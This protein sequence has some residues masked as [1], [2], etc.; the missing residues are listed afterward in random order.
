MQDLKL[1]RLSKRGCGCF[2]LFD[3][4]ITNDLS[5]S[6]QLVLIFCTKHGSFVLRVKKPKKK[7]YIAAPPIEKSAK[8]LVSFDTLAIKSDVK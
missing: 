2:D 5:M 7:S 6:Y 8:C 4:S 1:I 3:A